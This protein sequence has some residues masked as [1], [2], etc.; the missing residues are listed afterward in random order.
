MSAEILQRWKS[1]AGVYSPRPWVNEDDLVGFLHCFR[2]SGEG[3]EKVFADVVRGDEILARLKEVYRATDGSESTGM[4]LH[5]TPSAPPSQTVVLQLLEEHVAKLKEIARHVGDAGLA[6]SLDRVKRYEITEGKLPNSRTSQTLAASIRAAIDEFIGSLT[7]VESDAELL[8]EALYSLAANYVVRDYVL[9]PLFENSAIEEPFAAAF[10]LWSFDVEF[11]F[12]GDDRI[13]AKISTN[14]K[15]KTS[16]EPKSAKTAKRKGKPPEPIAHLPEASVAKKLQESAF[17]S[18]DPFWLNLIAKV[19][20]VRPRNLDEITTDLDGL[21]RCI[22]TRGMFDVLNGKQQGWDAVKTGWS[23]KAWK[24]QVETAVADERRKKIEGYTR[25]S[26]VQ[27]DEAAL[28]LVGAIALG[29]DRFADFCGSRLIRNFTKGDELTGERKWNATPFEPFAIRL[30]AK[31]RSREQELLEKATPEL[32]NE[33]SKKDPLFHPILDK[34]DDETPFQG[35]LA[36]LCNVFVKVAGDAHRSP[37]FNT[38]PAE[39]VAIRRIRSELGFPDV[40]QYHPLMESSVAKVQPVPNRLAEDK[41]FNEIL[42]V[43]RKTY[44]ALSLEWK[45]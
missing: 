29:E 32:T 24:Y 6:S 20:N 12:P 36:H 28:C 18:N 9:W 14:R 40:G 43:C 34:W 26:G 41:I 22:S 27:L 4:Y 21:G 8:T 44:P 38:F 5:P 39:H 13:V 45:W 23:Y 11:T 7:P 3:L 42:E 25:P 19:L 1:I 31:W 37:P 17:F 10:R 2:P 33:F 35:A 30:Y 15:S 16:G